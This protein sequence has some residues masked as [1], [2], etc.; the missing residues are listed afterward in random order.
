LDG[1]PAISCADHRREYCAR[2][3]DARVC[4]GRCRRTRVTDAAPLADTL[5]DA[6]EPST[7]PITA[8]DQAP[9]QEGA[10]WE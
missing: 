9:D 5:V 8:P 10:P 6:A 2:F 1:F 7:A 3:P 4:S